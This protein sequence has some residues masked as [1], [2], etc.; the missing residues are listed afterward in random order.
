VSTEPYI[1]LFESEDH[2]GYECMPYYSSSI[3]IEFI[4]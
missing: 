1:S 2:Y 3:I 4:K